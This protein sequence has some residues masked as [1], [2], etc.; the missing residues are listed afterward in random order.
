M[1]RLETGDGA[2]CRLVAMDNKIA[3][4]EEKQAQIAGEIGVLEIGLVVG[5]GREQPQ[6]RAVRT[7]QL[8]EHFAKALEEGR[9]ALDIHRPDDVRKGLLIGDPVFQDEA[10]A[11]RC[12][13]A[14]AEHPPSPVGPAAEIDGNEADQRLAGAALIGERV[15]EFW[16]LGDQRA[17]QDAVAHQAPL[18]I[19]VGGE[20]FQEFGPLDETVGK[21]GP[22]ERIDDE[23]GM[24]KRPFPRLLAQL[25]RRI[26][27]V[28][29][30]GLRQI[31]PGALKALD[32]LGRRQAEQRLDDPAR[33]D[34][35][36]SAACGHR[37]IGPCERR[38][39]SRPHVA[40]RTPEGSCY[41]SS[42]L[43]ENCLDD[44]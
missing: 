32:P 37:R 26:D 6:P 23:G 5:P 29:D 22:F 3:A 34:H 43:C 9:Q 28:E 42:N 1:D 30:P 27:P 25:R 18:A 20:P 33:S 40:L 13:G 2:N 38:Q 21:L 16:V 19:D 36:V 11:G 31:L 41:S 8:V 12:L 39:F 14:I 4:F 17:G 15:D 35:L 7:G 10:R 24:G 44:T